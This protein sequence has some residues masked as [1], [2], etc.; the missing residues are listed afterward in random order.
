VFRSTRRASKSNTCP[1]A[2]RGRQAGGAVG[3]AGDASDTAGS[4]SAR[5]CLHT[6]ALALMVSAQNGHSL[7]PAV[8]PV[9]LAVLALISAVSA[10][11][12]LVSLLLI[13]WPRRQR[14]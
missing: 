4:G 5:Q 9:W 12:A 1:E 2:I 14:R 11:V 7:V 6:T 8:S 13:G 3:E 10:L